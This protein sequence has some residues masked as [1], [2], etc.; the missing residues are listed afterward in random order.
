MSDAVLLTVDEGIAVVT[1]NRPETLNASGPEL[2]AAVAHVWSKVRAD[3]SVR[4]VVLTGAG[5]AFC[6]GGDLE[7]L[8]RMAEDPVERERVMTE[9][10]MLVREL[11]SVEVP[12]V[13]AVNG[14]A[15]GLGCSLAAFCDLVVM[16][17]AA[18]LA[19]PHVTLG[20]VA[21]DGG[22]LVFP[23]VMSPQ[24][25]KEAILLGTRID[26]EQAL[27]LGIANRVS[28]AG[29]SVAVAME[30]ARAL[31]ALPPQA[32][33]ESKKLLNAPVVQH[34]TA[35]LEEALA[36]ETRSFDEPELQANVA[37]MLAKAAARRAARG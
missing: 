12:I 23:L 33:R 26:A 2:H 10:G 13:A 37:A 4:A 32:V 31:A 30:L 3:A 7:L 11:L 35:H 20:L 18:F 24:R 22:A 1:L 19:D 25:A 27:A 15:V 29:E 34:V 16:D 8:Q 9:A 36:A 17:P 14:A 21:A 6:A 5:K 28:P